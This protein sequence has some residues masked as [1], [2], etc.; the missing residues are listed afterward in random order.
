V[1]AGRPNSRRRAS[2]TWG[3]RDS[4]PSR[5]PWA[6]AYQGSHILRVGLVV[7]RLSERLALKCDPADRA[8]DRPRHRAALLRLSRRTCAR[9]RRSGRAGRDALHPTERLADRA[10]DI[11]RAGE[12]ADGSDLRPALHL[13]RYG[14]S[15][16]SPRDDQI[17]RAVA[18]R[19]CRAR[20]FSNA[21]RL[22]AHGFGLA[23]DAPCDRV[24]RK[25]L[26]RCAAAVKL[27]EPPL[28]QKA[29]WIP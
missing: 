8:K 18:M 13:A 24:D 4:S 10:L 20:R 29:R 26:R 15:Y 27:F 23:V 2:S 9:S 17:V 1:T 6:D 5:R 22:H 14:R 25:P 19:S 28:R 12:H 16:R 21:K 11:A 3:A 7:D